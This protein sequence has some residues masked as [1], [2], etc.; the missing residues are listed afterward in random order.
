MNVKSLILVVT[1]YL[2][3]SGLQAQ[4]VCDLFTVEVE[5][6]AGTFLYC[7]ELVGTETFHAIASYDSDTIDFDDALFV[8][9]WNFDG[10]LYQGPTASHT[11]DAPG[12]YPFTLRVE[13]P[14]RGCVVYIE[15]VVKV[16]TIPTFNGTEAAVEEACAKEIFGLTGVANMTTWTNF[17][18][19]VLETIAIPKPDE[20]PYE[21][22]LFFDVF[23]E[24]QLIESETDIDRICFIVDHTDYGQLE[25]DL[26]C[27][28][29][30]VV[31]LKSFSEGGASLGEPVD[32]LWDQTTPGKGY[33]YCF[34][35]FPQYGLMEET[36]PLQHF[37]TDMAGNYLFDNYLPPGSYTSSQPLS[38]LRGC[39]LNGEWTIR[40]SDGMDDNKGFL[41]GWSL[42]FN[43][44]YY[45]DSLM[46]TPEV[47]DEQWYSNERE[48]PD[49]PASASEDDEGVYTYRFEIRDDFGCLYDTTL[50][51]SILPLPK[52]EIVSDLEMPVCE[53][54]SSILRVFPTSGTDF[55][56][57]Y[58]WM[59]G[60]VDMPDRIFD[61]IMIK[62]PA[63][64]TL[65][66]TDTITGCQDFFD[67]DFTDQNCDLTIPNVFTP[68]ADG[69]NDVFEI[70]NME[71][72]PQSQLVIYN[73]WGK[74]VFE[75]SDYYN[76][77]WDGQG[78]PD[79]VYFYVIRY[80]RRGEIQFTEGSVTIIR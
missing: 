46:F 47:V 38:L 29:G 71:H 60:G 79:G 76:N 41:H 53:G 2:F 48:I 58:Q 40:V 78:N 21:S 22:S 25:F 80:E 36:S 1:M 15:K 43:E 28:N 66:V 34:S 74:K 6:A 70:L 62:E 13:D 45:P 10:Q 16:G 39:P 37:Y 26:E 44:E 69:I 59:L 11:F 67:F 7:P 3:A 23:D 30:T 42:F 57:E 27:P 77:W 49:N 35:P 18:T 32:I 14:E 50:T 63:T 8:Y 52:A 20:P 24:G 51:V 65:M 61:T 55:D 54:D 75:H 4:S 68:N 19:S 72:Y 5:A 33:Q 12:A 31:T 73:R 56:W 9:E 17:P 64:Y